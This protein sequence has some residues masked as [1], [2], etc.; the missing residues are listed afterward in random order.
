MR[1][2]RVGL[3]EKATTEQR[4]EAG[5]EASTSSSK[6]TSGRRKKLCKDLESQCMSGMF[7]WQ[8]RTVWA[9]MRDRGAEQDEGRQAGRRKPAEV[10]P[11]RS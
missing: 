2:V 9:G 6:R 7:K 1:E 4:L 3:I 5:E 8:L 11:S 10:G